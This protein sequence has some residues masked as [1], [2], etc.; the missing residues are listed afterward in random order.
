MIKE[1]PD[2]TLMCK[3]CVYDGKFECLGKDRR[4]QS[5]QIVLNKPLTTSKIR[6]K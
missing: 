4:I 5:Y 2:P 1:V 3:G 6:R